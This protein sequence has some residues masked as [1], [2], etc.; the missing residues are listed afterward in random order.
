MAEPMLIAQNQ[1][2]QC[3]LLPGLAG[4]LVRRWPWRVGAP[5]GRG[6]HHDAAGLE[7]LDDAAGNETGAAD[8][9]DFH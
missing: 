5:G 6:D 1:N 3:H 4:S 9:E 2:V 8:E 7:G